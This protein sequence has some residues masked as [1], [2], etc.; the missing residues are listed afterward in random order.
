MPCNRF[1]AILTAGLACAL[2]AGCAA[3][4]GAPATTASVESA[5]PPQSLP[6]AKAQPARIALLLPLGG[7]SETAQIARGMKQAAELALFDANDPA[8]QLI[9]KDD[10]GTPEGAK[11][12]ADAAIAEGA[13]II[14][15][16]L[17]GK[18]TGGAAAAARPSRI[19]VLSFS[20]D[21][22]A[23]ADGVYLM[24]FLAGD[25]VGRVVSYAAQRGKTRFVALIPAN[26]YGQS[27]EPAFRQAIAATGAILV[28]AEIY[29]PDARG[30]LDSAKR[31]LAVI[32]SSEGA[33]QPVDALFLPGGADEIAQ[34]A[35]LIAYSGI[36][37]KAV[38]IIGTSALDIAASARDEVLTGAWYASSD[39]ETWSL[40]SQKF[41]KTFG[42]AP[43]RLASLAYDATAIAI[44]LA[45]VPPPARYAAERLR[46]AD[47]FAGVDGVVRFSAQGK[48]ER[49]LAVLEIEKYRSVVIDPA[50][51]EDGPQRMSRAP[52]ADRAP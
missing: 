5:L 22:A 8:I 25:E 1:R 28:A 35:P 14:L 11:A 33:G 31:I 6:P 46:R 36:D 40:F 7:F 27:I 41:Q 10:G 18:A 4:L 16:P 20:N 49:G 24:S 42:R 43:P 30:I 12:A 29:T 13:E 19:P 37:T 3:K 45:K 32:K 9:V 21:P 15:G 50:P 47:G 44:E 39:P 26:A 51:R 23:A 38:K 2:L 52:E 34:L 48:A 17:F